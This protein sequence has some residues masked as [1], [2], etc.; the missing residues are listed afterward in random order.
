MSGAWRGSHDPATVLRL[1]SELILVAGS[2]CR[3]RCGH[4][5]WP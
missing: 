2:D 4:P 1:W 5:P 3:G